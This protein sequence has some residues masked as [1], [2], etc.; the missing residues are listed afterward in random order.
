MVDDGRPAA[1]HHVLAYLS[2]MFNWGIAR[3]AY[4]LQASPVI[5]GM[6]KDIIGAK[7]PRQRVLNEA[8]AGR[9]LAG[10]VRVV[11]PVRPVHEDADCDRPAVARGR[12]SA[13][14]RG[15]PGR[16]AVGQLRLEDEGRRGA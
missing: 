9:G 3:D 14:E 13:M 1:A 15:R 8:E 5:R 10:H 2:A 16:Q 12:P 4:G 6:A 7:K 11:R